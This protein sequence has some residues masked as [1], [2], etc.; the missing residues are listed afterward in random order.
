METMLPPSA[1]RA[2]KNRYYHDCSATASKQHY[3]LCLFTIEAH[4]RGQK[5][6]ETPC[7][8]AIRAGTCPALVMRKQE[9]DAGHAIF[10]KAPDPEKAVTVTAA[11]RERMANVNSAS[12]QRGRHG[13]IWG[14]AESKSK[15]QAKAQEAKSMPKKPRPRDEMLEFNGATLVNALVDEVMSYDEIKREIVEVCKPAALRRK[16]AEKAG[17]KLKPTVFDYLT[18]EE[19]REFQRLKAEL[20]KC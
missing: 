4:E 20:V 11:S 16:A 10:Y 9:C 14:S 3:G 19:A 6:S 2:G 17:E 12:Y 7:L 8:A 1:S 5:L 18:A 13:V 15:A